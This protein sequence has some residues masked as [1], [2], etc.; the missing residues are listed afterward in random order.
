MVT[1][2]WGGDGGDAIEVERWRF[3]KVLIKFY[4]LT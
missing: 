4:F 2:S 1:W 3:S